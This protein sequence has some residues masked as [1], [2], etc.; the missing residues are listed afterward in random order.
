[1]RRSLSSVSSSQGA[2]NANF[3][4]AC[5]RADEA[6]KDLPVFEVDVGLK[7]QLLQLILVSLVWGSSVSVS[8][9]KFPIEQ[10][11]WCHCDM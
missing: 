6:G 3:K 8:L 11:F 2:A 9:T 4:L 10:H 5:I 7:Q 1:M